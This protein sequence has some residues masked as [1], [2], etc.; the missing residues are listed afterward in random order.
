MEKE[1]NAIDFLCVYYWMVKNIENLL[2]LQFW[3]RTKRLLSRDYSPFNS[4][5]ICPP[6]NNIN[7]T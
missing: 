1:E 4:Y 6:I 2:N 5:V 3:V 7:D